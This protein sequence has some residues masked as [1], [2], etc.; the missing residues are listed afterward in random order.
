MVYVR[1][2]KIKSDRYLY[3]VRSVWD[4][5]RGTSRQEIVKYLGKA[6]NVSREDVPPE[7]RDDPKILAALA[8]HSPEDARKREEATRRSREDLY[9]GLAEGSIRGC[10]GVFEGYKAASGVTGFLDRVLRPVMQRIGDDWEAGRIDIATEHV[11]SNVAQALVKVILDSVAPSGGRGRVLICVPF[12]E[13][14]RL[15]CDVLE[16]FL[17]GKGFCVY[18]MGAP[19][20]TESVLGFISE[21]RPDAV[22]VSVTLPDNLGAAGRL[23]G[24]IRGAHDVP[25]LVGGYAVQSGEVPDMPGH[26]IGD[27][28]LDEIPRIIR[29]IRQRTAGAS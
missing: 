21:H 9:R 1:A 14:H 19:V 23:V 28:G 4:S 15:G 5:G 29:R 12:G 25:V 18:N 7:Y 27:V 8:A 10:V 11:A 26:V 24:R 2:K 13:E 16:T 6:S 20:P 3:L 22:L 17:S